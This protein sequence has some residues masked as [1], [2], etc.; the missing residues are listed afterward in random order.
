MIGAGKIACAAIV[1]ESVARKSGKKEQQMP[2]TGCKMKE[3]LIVLLTGKPV[4]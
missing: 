3:L 1:F 2:L 4:V